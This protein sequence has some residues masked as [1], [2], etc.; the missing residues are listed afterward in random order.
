MQTGSN[1]GKVLNCSSA[2]EYPKSNHI[3]KDFRPL[4]LIRKKPDTI[5]NVHIT[6]YQALTKPPELKFRYGNR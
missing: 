1:N 6:V 5:V 3:V 2:F 4:D